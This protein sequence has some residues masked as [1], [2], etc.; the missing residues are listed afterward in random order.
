MGGRREP[1]SRARGRGVTGP[2]RSGRSFVVDHDDL[3][4]QASGSMSYQPPGHMPGVHIPGTLVP[5]GAVV[6][7]EQAAAQQAAQQAAAQQAAA[8]AAARRRATLLLLLSV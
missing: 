2:W 6:A 7:Q 5:I 3:S 8:Q 1:H 4:A